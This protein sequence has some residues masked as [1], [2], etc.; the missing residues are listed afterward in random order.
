MLYES[1]RAAHAFSITLVHLKG[2]LKSHQNQ[3]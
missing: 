3:L 1:I 2:M